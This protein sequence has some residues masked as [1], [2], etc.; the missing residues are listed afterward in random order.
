MSTTLKDDIYRG[1]VTLDDPAIIEIQEKY[2]RKVI[3]IVNGY[4]NVLYEICN[5]AG[6]QSHD[7][8]DHLIRVIKEYEKGKPKQHPVGS[9]GGQGTLNA[10]T[11]QS[12][13][14][15]ISPD[16]GAGDEFADEYRQG[17]YTWGEARFDTRDKVVIL[18]T[19]HLWGI[20]GDE[21]FAWKNFCRG[22]NV[23]YMDP[24]LDMP[25]HFFEHPRWPASHNVHL[26]REM[27]SIRRYAQMM[28]LNHCLPLNAL[29]TTGYCLALPGRSYLVYQPQS[30]PFRLMLV[31][32]EY[33]QQWHDP[34]T[35]E[36]RPWEKHTYADGWTTFNPPMQGDAVLYIQALK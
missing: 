3:D 13:A 19:D 23:I 10:R 35:G 33:R 29:S 5:E 14:D 17:R 20:G 31:G 24:F 26:R 22:Y 16:C 36:T 8:Q 27:G 9:T 15:W 25:W 30:G 6:K 18:D 1:W 11:Y 4:D 32:G 28:D 21:E 2:I 34:S 7:W 12:P